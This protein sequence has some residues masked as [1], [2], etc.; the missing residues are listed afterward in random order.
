[1]ETCDTAMSKFPLVI[2]F[3][4]GILFFKGTHG[5]ATNITG[6]TWK[7]TWGVDEEIPGVETVSS[8]LNCVKKMPPVMDILG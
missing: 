7:F 2:T 5:C 1:M 6:A 4:L 8:A 3:C